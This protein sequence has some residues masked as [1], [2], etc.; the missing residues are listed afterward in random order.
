MIEPANELWNYIIMY[1]FNVRDYGKE[2]DNKKQQ[3]LKW[4][5]IFFKF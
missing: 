3:I 4:L 2:V 1:S 5:F